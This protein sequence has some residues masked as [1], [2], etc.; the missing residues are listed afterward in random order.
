MRQFRSMVFSAVAI[1]ALVALSAGAESAAQMPAN[2][3]HALI[4]H[5]A[6]A[7][8]TVIE[9]GKT[10]F[11]K[12]PERFY[13]A[14]QNVLDPVVDFES[15]ARGVM[16]VHYRK[17]TPE[18]RQRFY[19]TFKSGLVRTYGKALLEFADQKI[20][21][22]P[23]ERPPRQP[24]RDTVT[25]EVTSDEGR[26]YPVVYSMRL[27]ADGAWRMRNIIINGINI[28]L[29]YRNQFASAMKSP[30]N[31]GNIDAVINAWTVTIEDVDPMREGD[32]ATEAG[33]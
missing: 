16:A 30:Q 3:P 20:S 25:M 21:V 10:Y 26:I 1:S 32:A 24:D 4:S 19:D 14:I 15:F 17:A 27:E 33:E 29:T 9:E 13:T 2:G 5:T 11:D 22:V 12:D 28:G 31:R 6:D 7:L 23:P 8:I 18:Q